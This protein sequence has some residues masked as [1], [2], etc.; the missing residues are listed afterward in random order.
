MNEI[1]KKDN[2]S[3][4][5]GSSEITNINSTSAEL[6]RT[7]IMVANSLGR[8]LPELRNRYN[9]VFGDKPENSGLIKF[10]ALHPGSVYKIER[11]NKGEI[12]YITGLSIQIVKDLAQIYGHLIYGIQS[13]SYKGNMSASAEA[14]CIDLVSNT[15]QSREFEVFFPKYVRDS[16]NYTEESYKYIYMVGMKRVRSCLE[17]IMP[18]WMTETAYNKII[19]YKQNYFKSVGQKDEL[20]KNIFKMAKSINSKVKKEDDIYPMIDYA[21]Q[22]DKTLKD[23]SVKDLIHIEE[24][25]SGIKEQG[26]NDENNVP[27]EKEKSKIQN[28][29]AVLKKIKENEQKI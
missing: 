20:I 9:E 24:I 1:I 14:Y 18:L 10:Y 16:K 23:L 29:D 22:P 15:S 12:N 6:I 2:V 5:T 11:R 27:E 21:M 17:K 8:G 13:V 26:T 7:R 25:L 3:S 28:K 4:L 19:Q